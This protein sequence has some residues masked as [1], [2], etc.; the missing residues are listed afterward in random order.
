[1]RTHSFEQNLALMPDGLAKTI[2][3]K[4]LNSPKPDFSSLKKE[5]DEYVRARFSEM[6][7]AERRAYEAAP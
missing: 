5:S 7:A 2:Y 6:S 3:L 4:I 1:M